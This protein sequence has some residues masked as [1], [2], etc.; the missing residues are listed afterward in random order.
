[1]AEKALN[2]RVRSKL[3][4]VMF[5]IPLGSNGWGRGR[6]AHGKWDMMW[7]IPMCGYGR[8]RGTCPVVAK[9]LQGVGR[10]VLSP[11]PR[12]WVM[13]SP[14]LLP[15]CQFERYEAELLAFHSSL[16]DVKTYV[17]L[18]TPMIKDEDNSGT[19]RRLWGG[20]DG[21]LP[22]GGVSH[23]SPMPLERTEG[24]T[25]PLP[26]AR[27]S[28][29]AGVDH[30]ADQQGPRGQARQGRRHG[31]RRRRCAPPPPPP[32]DSPP[33][34]LTSLYVVICPRPPSPPLPSHS[35][36]QAGVPLEPEQGGEVHRG[37]QGARDPEGGRG[38][39]AASQG[40]PPPRILT[41]IE[42]Q[43]RGGGARGTK[44]NAIL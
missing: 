34:S 5:P 31:L 33:P 10:S 25:P 32:K 12:G 29:R 42:T 7:N 16:G 44:A 9:L 2:D 17:A 23:P 35:P 3:C 41:A 43:R 28:T 4:V 1:M 14:P 24:H 18:R 40:T 13:R 26:R 6:Q 37:L 11:P 15:A 19:M 38:L 21:G 39:Q 8:S 20:G 27:R 22:R 36:E 30:R